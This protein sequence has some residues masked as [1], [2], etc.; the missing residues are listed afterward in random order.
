MVVRYVKL[1]QSFG[2]LKTLSQF[3]S[4]LHAHLSM[5]KVEHNECL[6]NVLEALAGF[7]AEIVIREIQDLQVA[8]LQHLESWQTCASDKARLQVDF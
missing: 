4:A 3:M 1:L 2:K 7:V 8:L 6:C 5:R